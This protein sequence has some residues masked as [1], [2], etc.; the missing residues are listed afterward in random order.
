MDEE[1]TKLR[2]LIR[3]GGMWGGMKK[4]EDLR[5]TLSLQNWVTGK[6]VL[7]FPFLYQCY[8][9]LLSNLLAQVSFLS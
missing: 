4:R 8:V 1:L 6:M 2:Q 3:D 7:S 5:N 9:L